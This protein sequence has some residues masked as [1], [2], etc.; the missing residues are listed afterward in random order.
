MLGHPKHHDHLEFTTRCKEKAGRAPTLENLLVSYVPDNVKFTVA[1][2]KP[3][4]SG[5]KKLAASTHTGRAVLKHSEMWVAIE[6]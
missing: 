5:F 1:N 4:S 3:S 2:D 6:S